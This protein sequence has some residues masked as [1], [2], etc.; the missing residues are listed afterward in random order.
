MYQKK[1][2]ILKLL[3]HVFDCHYHR[4][5]YWICSETNCSSL[6]TE[7]IL[8]FCLFLASKKK[9]IKRSTKYKNHNNYLSSKR[10]FRH[11]LLCCFLSS[12]FWLLRWEDC[13]NRGSSLWKWEDGMRIGN[14]FSTFNNTWHWFSYRIK[15]FLALPMVESGFGKREGVQTATHRFRNTFRGNLD[16]VQKENFSFYCGKL[17]R[18]DVL[19]F[20]VNII[21][22]SLWKTRIQEIKI[23]VSQ[24]SIPSIRNSVIISENYF[25]LR[26]DLDEFLKV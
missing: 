3:M 26:H 8:C 17:K 1:S 5:R 19:L 21:G 10:I 12:F 13:G 9:I 24:K 25:K 23:L 14:D 11:F 18:T 22:R 7:I 2:N 20:E 16:Y 4:Y 6:K 15:D